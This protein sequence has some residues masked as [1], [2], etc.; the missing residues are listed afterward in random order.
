MFSEEER[1]RG[2][3][4]ENEI[5]TGEGPVCVCSHIKSAHT[6]TLHVVRRRFDTHNTQQE[7]RGQT[8]PQQI[9]EAAREQQTAT[10]VTESHPVVKRSLDPTSDVFSGGVET[11]SA[12]C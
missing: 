2:V 1:E 3:S 10:Q 4:E 6:S 8:H 9:R 5:Q 11:K 12:H 7:V